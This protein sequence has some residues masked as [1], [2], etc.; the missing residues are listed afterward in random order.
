MRG[1]MA[2][3]VSRTAIRMSYSLCKF[4]QKRGLGLCANGPRALMRVLK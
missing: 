4:G 3:F 1:S 2:A